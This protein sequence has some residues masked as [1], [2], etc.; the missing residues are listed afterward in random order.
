VQIALKSELTR[1]QVASDLGV[2]LLTLNKWV[3]KHR[4]TE[5][6]SAKAQDLG[7]E[8][9]RL[10]RETRAAAAQVLHASHRPWQPILLSR[11][12][13]ASAP[14]RIPGIDERQE[15]LL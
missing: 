2:G 15:Q 8:N 1:T 14:A 12:S 7:R 3:T 10:R 13:E 9:E 5:I 11:L 6:L 4:D